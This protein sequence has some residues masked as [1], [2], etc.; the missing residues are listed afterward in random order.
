MDE[1]QED[2]FDI[3]NIIHICGMNFEYISR[4]GAI[5]TQ[6]RAMGTGKYGYSL[7]YIN[8]NPHLFQ[9][10]ECT[11]LLTPET[12]YV[13]YTEAECQN[14][15]EA[16]KNMN[17]SLEKVKDSQNLDKYIKQ[18]AKQFILDI[19]EEFDVETVYNSLKKFVN[20]YKS[21]DKLIPQPINFILRSEGFDAV[22]SSDEVSCGFYNKGNVLLV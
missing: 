5:N 22:I 11:E 17:N 2:K 7:T 8:K 4:Q 10:K 16:V 9:T 6:K 3:N 21:G 13:L 18:I 1:C 14:Y 12:P 15:L 20:V 19:K